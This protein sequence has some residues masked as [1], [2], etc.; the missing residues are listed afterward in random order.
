LQQPD[1]I[2]SLQVLEE[3]SRINL[4]IQSVKFIQGLDDLTNLKLLKIDWPYFTEFRD[5]EG[6]KKACISLL[7]KLFTRVGE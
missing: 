5:M 7:F 3:L 1:V 4:G 2:G 6:H